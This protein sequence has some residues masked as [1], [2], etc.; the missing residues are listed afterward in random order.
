[1]IHPV[2]LKQELI[3]S[4]EGS[5]ICAESTCHWDTALP[6][7]T[8]GKGKWEGVFYLSLWCVY[9]AVWAFMQ[10][11]ERTIMI[12]DG[13]SMASCSFSLE[14][15][16]HLFVTEERKETELWGTVTKKHQESETER[17]WGMWLLQEGH[18]LSSRYS[19]A[20]VL[21]GLW[22][23]AFQFHHP[24]FACSTC[25]GFSCSI[26]QNNTYFGRT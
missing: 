20:P 5:W 14:L 6:Q 23:N 12:G 18:A 15:V 21:G 19:I 25:S 13:M 8:Q 3:S 24:T 2:S 26:L 9:K 1:M 7:R 10:K 22:W 17:F 16:I 11:L 4:L